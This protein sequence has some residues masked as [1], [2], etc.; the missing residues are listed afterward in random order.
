MNKPVLTLTVCAFASLTGACGG[1]EVM[2]APRPPEQK[3]SLHPEDARSYDIRA[4]NAKVADD[5][6]A[7]YELQRNTS[8]D[9]ACVAEDKWEIKNPDENDVAFTIK[10]AELD[11]NEAKAVKSTFDYFGHS[12]RKLEEQYARFQDFA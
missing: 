1:N 5:Q 9:L 11:P 2:Q 3:T 10:G 6:Q 8:L 7:I 4:L 12:F